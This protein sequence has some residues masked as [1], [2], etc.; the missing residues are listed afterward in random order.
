MSIK[1]DKFNILLTAKEVATL[2]SI[3]ELVANAPWLSET[4]RNSVYSLSNTIKEYTK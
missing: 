4:Q 1:K 2:K 3:L